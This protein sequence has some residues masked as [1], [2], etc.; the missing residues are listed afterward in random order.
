MK[1]EYKVPGGK[2]IVV[3]A[4]TWSTSSFQE[5]FFSNRTRRWTL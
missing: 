5:T 4:A 1:G 3:E 2:L